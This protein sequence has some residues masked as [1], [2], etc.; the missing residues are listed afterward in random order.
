MTGRP[1]VSFRG[2]QSRECSGPKS[3]R[4]ES[5]RKTE[6]TSGDTAFWRCAVNTLHHE[7]FLER[8]RLQLERNLGQ[9]QFLCEGRGC[10]HVCLTEWSRLSERMS[11]GRFGR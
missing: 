8:T 5:R 6:V 4:S 1:Q 3:I 7:D 11:W 10:D 2:A 9:G